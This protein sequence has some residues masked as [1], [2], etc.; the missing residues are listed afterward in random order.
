[1]KRGV[2]MERDEHLI[3]W[4]VIASSLALVFCVFLFKAGRELESVRRELNGAK[5]ELNTQ[6][7]ILTAT[8]K[9]CA[10]AWLSSNHRPSIVERLK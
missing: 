7:E 6:Q 1:M 5:T 4:G 2:K 3:W 10:D 9:E 8:V